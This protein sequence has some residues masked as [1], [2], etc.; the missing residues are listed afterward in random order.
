MSYQVHWGMPSKHLRRPMSTLDPAGSIETACLITD[1]QMSG[2][3]GVDLRDR[4]VAAGRSEPDHFHD[5]HFPSKNFRL[6]RT[7]L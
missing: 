4:L 6:W 2:M 5:G 1:V 7:A 3:S